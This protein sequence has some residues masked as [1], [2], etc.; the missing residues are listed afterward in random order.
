VSKRRSSN[1]GSAGMAMFWVVVSGS[2]LFLFLLGFFGSVASGDFGR[3][4]DPNAAHIQA[5]NAVGDAFDV[6]LKGFL[7]GAIGVSK[8]MVGR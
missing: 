1:R 2:V 5:A 6:G 7:D 4:P 3:T 8:G